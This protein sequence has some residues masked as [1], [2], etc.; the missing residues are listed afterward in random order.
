MPHET[1]STR[2]R[3]P[4]IRSRALAE[5]RYLS[6]HL[7]TARCS[8]LPLPGARKLCYKSPPVVLSQMG[9]AS[10]NRV[11]K[12]Y[13]FIERMDLGIRVKQAIAMAREALGED[14]PM[15]S[16]CHWKLALRFR[17][18]YVLLVDF[19]IDS[20]G[21]LVGTNTWTSK[22]RLQELKERSYS[23]YKLGLCNNFSIVK[24]C[25]KLAD[26]SDFGKLRHLGP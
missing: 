11:V 2:T 24:V 18:N 15:E 20:K 23:Y 9:K 10:K 21:R 5:V 14:F 4:F 1:R 3:E 25:N 7:R 26:K 19:T 13:L 17:K 12:A 22:P 16:T 8:G 6:L